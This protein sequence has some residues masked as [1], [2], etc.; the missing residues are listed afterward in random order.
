MSWFYIEDY[1]LELPKLCYH[2]G[3]R[4]MR[5]GYRTGFHTLYD[6]KRKKK[7]WRLHHLSYIYVCVWKQDLVFIIIMSCRQYGYPWPSLA[8]PPYR[9]LLLA[10]PQGYIL[11]SHRAAVCR[12]ELVLNWIVWMRTVWL[13]WIAWNRNVFDN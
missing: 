7:I 9:S 10:G 12:F 4:L 11:Y 8:T 1:H 2:P 5:L 3:W 6:K 13:N